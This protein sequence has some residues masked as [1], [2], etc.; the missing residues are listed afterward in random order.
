MNLLQK[1]KQ[2]DDGSYIE[3]IENLDSF[4]SICSK[5]STIEELI[6]YLNDL[7]REV[8]N[9]KNEKSKTSHNP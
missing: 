3:Q 2:A 1:G 4:E 7:N 8:E 9:K 6:T 5:Y